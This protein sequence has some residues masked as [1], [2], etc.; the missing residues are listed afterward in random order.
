MGYREH[1]AVAALERQAHTKSPGIAKVP[2][3]PQQ[4]SADTL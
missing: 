4:G 3:Y 1:L 2:H